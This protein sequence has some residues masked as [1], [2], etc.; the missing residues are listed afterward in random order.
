MGVCRGSSRLSSGPR[1]AHRCMLQPATSCAMK[2]ARF[3][4]L[5]TFYRQCFPSF[6][7][8]PALLLRV[9]FLVPVCIIVLDRWPAG[10]GR[11]GPV[12]CHTRRIRHLYVSGYAFFGLA[13]LPLGGT[14]AIFVCIQKH[15]V[16]VLVFDSNERSPFCP[17]RSLPSLPPAIMPLAHYKNITLTSLPPNLSSFL[18]NNSNRWPSPSSSSAS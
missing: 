14:R 12:M 4:K 5:H 3:P 13:I 10:L 9:L 1:R 7:R 18:S 2:H 15:L 17:S 11:G 16:N 6:Q 8:R